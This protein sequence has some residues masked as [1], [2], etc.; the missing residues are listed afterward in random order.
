MAKNTAALYG[1]EDDDGSLCT[2]TRTRK[3]QSRKIVSDP[4]DKASGTGRRPCL[5]G[6][7]G[8]SRTSHQDCPLNKCNVTT[9]ALCAPVITSVDSGNEV[10]G[11]TD[12]L[13]ESEYPGSEYYSSDGS[14]D[15]QSRGNSGD[16]GS[17]DNTSD[18]GEWC[19]C[20][21]E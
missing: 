17:S 15:E 11:A 18:E 16:E 5:C 3:G 4:G 2:P 1:P 14:G 21:G 12:E 13:F 8:H 9:V 6:S 10:S 7:L 19:I 20:G